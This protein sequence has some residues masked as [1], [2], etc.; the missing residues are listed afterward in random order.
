[1]NAVGGKL[2]HVYVPVRAPQGFLRF[3]LLVGEATGIPGIVV[4]PEVA[5]NGES[6]TGLWRIVHEGSGEPLGASYG[7]V[8]EALAAAERL[9]TV[10]H[11]RWDR[12]PF[13]ST[14]KDRDVRAQIDAV[15]DPFLELAAS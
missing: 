6:F 2:T 14:G 12:T 4:V 3:E 1:M 8:G 5:G 11:A 7:T 15:L 10:R 9:A 13:V